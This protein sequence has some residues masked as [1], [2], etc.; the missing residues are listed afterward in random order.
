MNYEEK[1]LKY[2][3]KYLN[4]KNQISGMPSTKATKA[5]IIPKER[6]DKLTG[7]KE[8]EDV[9]ILPNIKP[10]DLTGLILKAST[11][12]YFYYQ[13]VKNEEYYI[14]L[15][16]SFTT[17]KDLTDDIIFNFNELRINRIKKELL[18][19]QESI[20]EIISQYPKYRREFMKY[21]QDLKKINQD[22]F[23]SLTEIMTDFNDQS[24]KILRYMFYITQQNKKS[25]KYTD[26]YQCLTN[27]FYA[28]ISDYEYHKAEIDIQ[29]AVDEIYSLLGDKISEFIKNQEE[30]DEKERIDREIADDAM[31]QLIEEEELKKGKGKE[32]KQGKKKPSDESLKEGKQVKVSSRP[33]EEKKESTKL[34]KPQKLK[35]SS[36]K[37]TS[38]KLQEPLK[39]S[40]METL[41]PEYLRMI[42]SKVESPRPTITDEDFNEDEDNKWH[43]IHKIN[44]YDIMQIYLNNKDIRDEI[45]L[46]IYERLSL[47]PNIRE[48]YDVYLTFENEHE[49]SH[50]SIH[51]GVN[52]TTPETLYHYKLS[53][54]CND[55][56]AY[57]VSFKFNFNDV[58]VFNRVWSRD[59][60][61]IQCTKINKRHIDLMKIIIDCFNE[62]LLNPNNLY[63]KILELQDLLRK[64]EDKISKGLIFDITPYTTIELLKADISKYKSWMK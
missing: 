64:T 34:V 20:D 58:F 55:G 46:K 61:R 2:K 62:S 53:M 9:F 11:N 27:D 33:L 63:K 32:K 37:E 18:D 57:N 8:N 48:D 42:P 5:A 40:S 19:N 51:Q 28:Q 50:L 12:L 41:L 6:V 4:L 45:N 39:P 13:Y 29:I 25:E 24:T 14:Y 17:L 60:S 59:N 30:L 49:P 16:N 10:E 15:N 21:I 3:E 52:N 36:E 47:R 56:T 1:Y 7:Y 35:T 43:I 23:I 44:F 38:V 54:R 26:E 22:L 31:L